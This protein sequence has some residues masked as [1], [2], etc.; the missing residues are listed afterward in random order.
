MYR[1]ITVA[2]S[3]KGGVGK[4]DLSALLI[5]C[6]SKAGSVLA[7]D[8]DADANLARALGVTVNKT[9]GGVRESILN[10]PAR[11][12]I[13]AGGKVMALKDELS[14]VIEEADDFDIVVMGRPEGEG[15]YCPVNHIIREVIDTLGRNYDFTVIDCEAGLEHLSRKTTRDVNFMIVVTEPTA[16]SI[17][18]AKRVERLAEEL[19]IN[20]GTIM[21]AANKVTPE[22]MPV[23]E[24]IAQEN[25]IEIAVHIPYDP[26]LAELDLVGRPAVEL[27]G[28]SPASLAAA[29]I[30]D[31]I[32][33]SWQE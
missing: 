21:V 12:P 17:L 20:F 27:P 28:D 10:A 13:A 6:L 4:T 18:T 3:G 22:M 8:A 19:S 16:N 7:I 1:G 32:L 14:T 24:R 33:K 2:V 9:V 26:A 29:E 15:C 5:R 30:C 11:S 23:L 31:I 25:G